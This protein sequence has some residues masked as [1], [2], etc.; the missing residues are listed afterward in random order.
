MKKYS[1]KGAMSTKISFMHYMEWEKVMLPV[2][3]EEFELIYIFSPIFFHSHD[4][5]VKGQ[6]SK[7]LEK[8]HPPPSPPPHPPPPLPFPSFYK[9]VKAINHKSI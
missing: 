1:V 2:V 7:N 6:L 9:L 5:L 4:Q 3:F 8:L